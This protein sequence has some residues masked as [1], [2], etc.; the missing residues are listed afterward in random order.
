MVGRKY[1][2]GRLN[3]S[4]QTEKSELIALYGR[5]R[6]G[7]TYLIRNSYAGHIRFEVTGL[8]KGNRKEQLAVFL[9]E[10]KR[11]SNKFS[12]LDEID[13]WSN[14]FEHLKIYINSLRGKSKKVI[15][16]D[17]FPWLDSHKSGFLMY[18]G[19]FWN[20]YCEKRDDLIVVICGSAASYMIRN[21]VKNRGSLH[22]RL[23][24]KLRLEPFTLTETKAFLESKNIHWNHYN[25]I[26]LYIALGGIPHYLS[27]IKKDES[28]VQNIQ[29]LCFDPNGDLVNEFDEVFQSLFNYSNTHVEIIRTL[30]KTHKGIM[31]EELIKQTGLSGGGHFTKA[32]DELISSGFVSNYPSIG[33][34]KKMTLFRLSD[35]YSRFYLK[36][37]EPNK[38][39]GKDFWKAMSQKQSYISWAGFNF[40]TICLKHV[41]R[42]KKA[43]G[44][45][46]IYSINSSWSVAGVQVDLVIARNDKWTNL[47]E[48][49]FYDKEY[50]IDNSELITLRNKIHTFKSNTKTKQAVVLTMLTTY[51][52]VK[53]A[54]CLEIVTNNLTMDILFE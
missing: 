7:K 43:L 23:S 3:E 27:K 47:C 50:T 34:R 15:F 36:Y 13:N 52:V 38:N 53:N 32:V 14:A 6:I 9:Q 1:E 45:E 42:I 37:V 20:T 54:N 29:R 18:F 33:R 17:E 21:I 51:G 5:R 25:I 4:L 40:E 12:E 28:V 16:I 10:L 39:Q 24:Y 22:A 44:I 11:V 2:I 31:R 35:E 49:K 26:H 19:H 48:M 41:D 8:Y 30:G 46:G